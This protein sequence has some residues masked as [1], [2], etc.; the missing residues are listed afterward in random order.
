[1]TQPSVIVTEQDGQLGVLPPS[2][3]ALL[4][5]V[6]PAG[7]DATLAI[8]TP[9]TYARVTDL[10]AALKSGPMLAAAARWIGRYGR[11]VCVVRSAATVEGSYLNAVDQV[12]GEIT[13]IVKTGAGNAT[14][15]EH[16]SSNPTVAGSCSIVFITGGTQGVAG[17]IYQVFVNGVGLTPVALG[18]G[19]T[20]PVGSTGGVIAVSTGGTIVANDSIVFTLV[21]EIPESAGELVTTGFDVG[22]S[23]TPSIDDTTHPND[24]Y[25]VYVKIISGGTR[26]TP[27]ITYQWSLDGGRT[28][29]PTTALGTATSI[30]IPGSGGVKID[31]TSGTIAAGATIA[32]PT[33]APCWNNTD[34]SD[35]LTALRNT[36][37]T[38]DLCE[39]VGPITPD[40][41]DVV[42][43][44]F[45]GMYAK[46]KDKAWIG[47]ARMPVGDETEA[48]YL[49]SLSSAFASKATVRGMVCAGAAKITSSVNGRKERRP[50]AFVMGAL[51]AS[52]DDHI[53]TAD[54]NLGPIVGVSIADANGNPDEHDESVYPG[55]DDARFCVARTW[56]GEAGVYV[57]RPRLFSPEGSDFQIM[58]HRRV[59]NRAVAAL[60]VYLRRRL[61]RDVLV[62]RTTGYIR[63]SEAAEIEARG[64]SILAAVLGAAPKA[65]GWTFVVSRTDNL[66][67][68]KTM[69]FTA[70]IVP[71]AYPET[72]ALTVG[73]SNPA[74]NLTAV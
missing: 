63:E 9:A 67:S 50:F 20:I 71:L 6:G 7:D 40:A 26:G 21:A 33:V 22:G 44:A 66:L 5:L 56:D 45:A 12:D 42:D 59:M 69:T 41:F 34:L 19:A 46:G 30:V 52:V 62:D 38:W 32:F 25:E 28:M 1:M 55:L 68:T 27:G 17:I 61:N 4:A 64:A 18:T 74:L 51:E 15:T 11:P 48:N 60:R 8:N 57:N 47:S 23:S 70:R 10:V 37:V 13:G 14:F 2:A 53:D 35:A 3:G 65:S 58:P 49:A 16:A 54:V 36:Q 24:D 43:L 31:F 73:F 72:A 39:I 29:S